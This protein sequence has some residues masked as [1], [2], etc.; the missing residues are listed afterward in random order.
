MPN[1]NIYKLP[2]RD[3]LDFYISNVCNL[4]CEECFT[5]SNYKFK[6]HQTWKDYAEIYKQWSEK[7]DIWSNIRILGGEPLLVPDI[8][9]WIEGIKTYWPDNKLTVTTNGYRL[10]HVKN[11]YDTLLKHQ[12]SVELTIARHN[13]ND[14]ET[15]NEIINNFLVAPVT[16]NRKSTQKWTRP[17]TTGDLYITDNNGVTII[18]ENQW[19]FSTSGV[20]FNTDLQK[21]NLHDSDPEKAHAVCVMKKCHSMIKGKLY[22]CVPS[23][24]FSEFDKQI[25]L[26]ISDE[27]RHLLNS[28][29]PLSVDAD[30]I[31][32][33]K[34]ILELNNS[35]PQCKFCPQDYVTKKIFSIEKKKLIR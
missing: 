5:L 18:V 28:Y 17:G 12:G 14:W 25:T 22:K 4:T 26:D 8:I 27:D 35:I 1:N 20:K 6:G 24:V 16:S 34:F 21:Y 32:T 9:D 2:I 15:I 13:P 19:I 3:H 31:T 23:F 10:N 11:L 33:Q 30:Y 29:A 7:L